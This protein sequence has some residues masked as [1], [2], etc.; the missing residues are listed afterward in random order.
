MNTTSIEDKILLKELIDKISILGDQ[1][2]FNNQVQLFTEHAISETIAEGKVILELKGRKV[3][4]QAFSEFLKEVSMV[5]HFN[6]QSLFSIEG[7]T[8]TGICYCLITLISSSRDKKSKMTIGAV[9]H[10]RYVRFD[11]QWLIEKRVGNFV[12]Q[13]KS[14]VK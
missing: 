12:W 8:A 7:D 14:E 5:H 6:G 9:Y 11:N 4:A 1:K 13:D 2:D 3:M 10:D